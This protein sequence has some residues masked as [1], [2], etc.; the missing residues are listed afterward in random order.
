MEAQHLAFGFFLFVKFIPF[1]V[2]LALVKIDSDC[3]RIVVFPYQSR[4]S[5]PKCSRVFYRS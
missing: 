4:M 5:L 2:L 3:S 1:L